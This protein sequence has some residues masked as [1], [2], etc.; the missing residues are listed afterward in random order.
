M[1]TLD[2]TGVVSILPPH[3]GGGF[4]AQVA[5]LPG[6]MSD[7][8]TREEAVRNVEGAIQSW[9]QEAQEL[10]RSIPTPSRIALPG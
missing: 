8:G 7:G 3:E 6:C 9:V 2:Y 4:I 10:G 5:D 1:G